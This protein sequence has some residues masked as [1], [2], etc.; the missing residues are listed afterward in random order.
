MAFFVF[1]AFFLYKHVLYINKC[2][3]IECLLRKCIT[4]GVPYGSFL[5]TA[6][7]KR[8]KSCKLTLKKNHCLASMSKFILVS[9]IFQNAQFYNEIFIIILFCK[10]T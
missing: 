9:E 2:L 1:L 10:Q 8:G 4:G 3:T 7:V 6:I 5:Q